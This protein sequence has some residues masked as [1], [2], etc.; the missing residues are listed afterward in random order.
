MKEFWDTRFASS[1][2][3]YGTKPNI[4]FRSTLD[5]LQP[6][7]LLL[8]GEGEGRNAVYAARYGWEVMA[9]DYSIEGRKK[10]MQLA[11][12]ENVHIDYY[13]DDIL[14]F[15][16]PENTFD[17]AALIFVHLPPKETRQLFKMI[18]DSLKPGG[19]FFGQL[20]SKEQLMYGSGGPKNENMLYSEQEILSYSGSLQKKLFRKHEK[21]IH[22]GDMHHGKASVI[23]F[24]FQK[25]EI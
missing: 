15:V 3:K 18:R 1:E 5:K 9:L 24:V 11:R 19:I 16:Y 25:P 14:H 6:G 2:Y 17:A 21:I 13:H 8:P 23:D 12:A 4:F 10:A 22:E 20:Y 7:K